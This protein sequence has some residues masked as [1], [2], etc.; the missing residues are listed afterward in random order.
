MLQQSICR[1][2]WESILKMFFEEI[3][4]S[5]EFGVLNICTKSLMMLLMKLLNSFSNSQVVS[6]WLLIDYYLTLS[7][8]VVLQFR[9]RI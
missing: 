7:V 8:V 3:G 2:H 5:W 9:A 1:S 6:D 4:L